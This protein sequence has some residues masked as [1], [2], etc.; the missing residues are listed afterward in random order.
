MCV[1]LYATPVLGADSIKSCDYA[2]GEANY[3][4]FRVFEDKN[5]RLTA[6]DWGAAPEDTWGV[7]LTFLSF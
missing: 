7:R 1:W 4:Y 6:V 2:W 3:R 5:A